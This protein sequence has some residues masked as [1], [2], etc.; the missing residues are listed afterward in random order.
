MCNDDF[1]CTPVS[2]CV[3]TRARSQLTC[4]GGLLLVQIQSPRPTLSPCEALL[5]ARSPHGHRLTLHTEP[6]RL[7]G[8]HRSDLQ[9][10]S[11]CDLSVPAASDMLHSWRGDART[12][13]YLTRTVCYVYVTQYASTWLKVACR[14]LALNT[15]RFAQ[16]CM[17]K[18]DQAPTPLPWQCSWHGESVGRLHRTDRES[19]V[20]PAECNMQGRGTDSSVP[21]LAA[22]WEPVHH[23]T[24]AT[25]HIHVLQAGHIREALHV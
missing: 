11:L 15:A 24:S 22:C 5:Q 14:C 17:R 25:L 13:C 20:N 2:W 7:S 18:E 3:R 16:L 6:W 4:C 19:C 10:S 1:A 21:C 23:Q 9:T 8:A 12:V